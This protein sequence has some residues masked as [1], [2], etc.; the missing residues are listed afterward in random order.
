VR[1][2]RRTGHQNDTREKACLKGA[3]QE[4]HHIKL[5]WRGYEHHGCRSEAPEHHDAEQRLTR[6][7]L[8]QEEIAR[9]LKQEISDEKNA[10]AQAVDGV[11]ERQGLLHLRLRITDID[12]IEISDHVGDQQ[13]G[14]EAPSTFE[15]TAL[16]AV[17][18]DSDD[19]PGDLL[20]VV[21]CMFV[22]P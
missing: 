21:G 15:N 20:A 17:L 11:V 12:A 5:E 6:A 18:S 7:D 16:R 22:P 8:L 14:N 1:P 3:E 2:S 13:Q 4:S 10:C 19:R 9:Y